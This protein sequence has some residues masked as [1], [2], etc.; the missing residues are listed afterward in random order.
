MHCIV[1]SDNQSHSPVDESTLKER[2]A[3]GR[4]IA[5]TQACREGNSEWKALSLFPEFATALENAPHTQNRSTLTSL[6]KGWT[7]KIY[8]KILFYL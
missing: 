8:Y 7:V 4:A 5:Q 1:G 3:Q 2:I 6:Q